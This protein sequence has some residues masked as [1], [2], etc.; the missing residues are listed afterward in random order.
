MDLGRNEKVIRKVLTVAQGEMGLHQ[1]LK[2]VMDFWQS[3]QVE[4]VDYRKKTRLIKG[5]DEIFT[6]LR[7]HINSL[8]GM[9]SSPYY[10]VS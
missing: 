10:K 2:Q 1:F 4:L 3:F 8:N 9:K 6:R 5:W 7:E